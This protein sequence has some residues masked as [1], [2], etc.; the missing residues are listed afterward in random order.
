MSASHLPHSSWVYGSHTFD[1]VCFVI[2]FAN[3]KML[4]EV[5]AIVLYSTFS[6]V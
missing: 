2:F 4:I 5:M 6:H 3:R 1:Y